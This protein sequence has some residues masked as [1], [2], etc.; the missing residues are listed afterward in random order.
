MNIL[1]IQYEGKVYKFKRLTSFEVYYIMETPINSKKVFF[2]YDLT[3]EINKLSMMMENQYEFKS[4]YIESGLSYD[5][6]P[7]SKT[8][9]VFCKSVCPAKTDFELC[10]I[11]Q[12]KFI[13]FC[14]RNFYLMLSVVEKVN[15]SKSSIN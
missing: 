14:Q 1:K 15:K 8:K 5:D 9:K 6:Y 12:K 4:G 2:S 7:T 3:F 10:N 13:E 11:T